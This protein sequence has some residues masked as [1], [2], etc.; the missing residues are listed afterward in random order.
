MLWLKYK[1]NNSKCTYEATSFSVGIFFISLCKYLFVA[2]S[3]AAGI[4]YFYISNYSSVLERSLYDKNKMIA[5]KYNEISKEMSKMESELKEIRQNDEVVYRT[6]LQAE[7]VNFARRQSNYIDTETNSDDF[8]SVESRLGD[9]K[10]L[11]K[12]Q[13][14]SFIKLKTLIDAREKFFDSL[15]AIQP[16]SNNSLRRIGDTFGMR[17]C[18]PVHK[19]PMMH[20]GI[21]YVAPVG[22]KVYATG[23]GIIK[24][25][26]YTAGY[27]NMI[28]LD[29]GRGLSTRYAH[30]S[31]FNVKAGERVVR[32]QCIGYVGCTGTVTGPHLHY[33]VIKD[34]VHINPMNFLLGELNPAQYEKVIEVAQSRRRKVA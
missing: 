20:K 21:D 27:G 7:P 33:E 11:M 31:K 2:G 6:L 10:N 4:S 5:E 1:Y 23:S 8:V 19:I 17:N 13:K 25:S 30:L 14:N 9:I 15:P 28:E 26:R 12:S 18:H 22:T 3:I 24:H 34:N 16:I 32:G 29:H